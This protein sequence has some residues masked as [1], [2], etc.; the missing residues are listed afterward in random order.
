MKKLLLFLIFLTCSIT[1]SAAYDFAIANKDGVKIYYSK[2]SANQVS[3]VKGEDQYAGNIVIPSSIKYDDITYSVTQLAAQSFMGCPDLLS[4][5]MPES[6]V[7][8]GEE[9]FENDWQMTS[10]TFS[11]NINYIGRSALEGCRSIIKLK[12][13]SKLNYIWDKTFKGCT[14]LEKITIP[15]SVTMIGEHSGYGQGTSPF[16]GCVKLNKVIIEDIEAWFKISFS[17]LEANPLYNAHN[18]YMGD[19]LVKEII[20]P[21]TITEINKNA[22]CGCTNEMSIE[23]P[24]TITRIGDSSF[25]FC[26]NLLAINLPNSITYIGPNSFEGCSSLT[27]VT[28]PRSLTSI[29]YA[30]FMGCSSLAS[31]TIPNSI[32]VIEESA[33]ASCSSLMSVEIP[34]SITQIERGVFSGCTAL[35]HIDIPNSVTKIGRLAFHQCYSLSSISLPNS[36]TNIGR[37]AFSYCTALETL[38]LPNSVTWLDHMAFY[39]C[40]SLKYLTIGSGISTLYSSQFD[41][42]TSL[43]K[44]ICLAETPPDASGGFS[45]VNLYAASLYVPKESFEQYKTTSP[46][47]E[48]GSIKKIGCYNL[49]YILDGE[50]YKSYELEEGYSIT[51]EPSPT[52]EGYTFSGWSE[53]PATMPAHD[54]T[55]SGTFTVNK[56]KLIYEVD[57]EEYK[58][59]ELDYGASITPEPAPT[60]EG[61]I[62]SG[63]SEIPETMPAH[64]ITVT[65]SF[66]VNKYKLIYKVD[67]AE[68]KSYEIEYGAKITP[69][70]TPIKEGYTFSG[71]SEIPEAM[72]AH[73]VTITGTFSINKYKLAYIVNG[74]EY[75]SYEIEYG[76]TII[77]E[78]SPTKEGYTFSGWSEIP[79]TMPAH[80]V[81]VIGTFT[82]NKYKL[83]YIVDGEEYKSYEL[84]YGTSITPE[85]APTK[86]GYTFSGWSEIPEM[87]PAHDVTVTGTFTKGNYK[88]TY[89]VDG[90]VYKTFSYDYG[91]VITPEPA[92]TKE[93]YTF[94]GWSEIPA[95]MPAHDVTVTGTFSI[96]S[97]KLTYV[98][99]GEEYKSHELEYGA[100]IIPEAEPT[101]DGYTFS[102]WSEIP[103]NMPAHDVTVTGSFTINSYKLTYMINDKVYKETIYEYGATIIPE[104]QPEGDYA[105]FE[106]TDLPQTMLAYDVTVSGKFLLMG[107]AN[108]NGIVD[109][110]DIEEVV[111]YIMGHPSDIINMIAADANHDGK[112]NVADIVEIT[113]II[114]K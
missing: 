28:I 97:Y 100:A 77:P 19:K 55:V 24:N 85:P 113:N 14:G 98:V 15:K 46:W 64:G 56:Y 53:I 73:D 60:K 31:L 50:E 103:E 88:L 65:G 45:N 40:T 38:T 37:E 34:N 110:V 42:C 4:V 89:M 94:S 86:E 5:I 92:P 93:G 43:Y 16:D 62:F 70:T 99:D 23:L 12:L 54:V 18:L 47:S 51:P 33:F 95:T 13:P 72:P 59:Y 6:I 67:G 20:L 27:S 104:P 81:T 106:W 9:A 112:V 68:Y 66:T 52:K 7:S 8:I 61:Y 91:D 96:N 58:S 90:E 48:F 1:I 3:V 44:V 25:R 108:G 69:E 35:Q 75:K 32:A 80:D 102:G 114:K 83:T 10:I 36:L 74:E 41:N 84:D 71:W 109:E 111:N 63:W 78:T 101:K 76:A 39:G 105:T 87:M 17:G 29:K 21:N 22:M 79:A 2:I 26:N 107:D 57:G 49:I 30:T 82:I 11:D